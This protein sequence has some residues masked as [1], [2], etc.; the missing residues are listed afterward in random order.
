MSSFPETSRVTQ[1][2][3]GDA[4]LHPSVQAYPEQ[5]ENGVDLSLLRYMLQLPPLERLRLMERKAREM[6]IL[7]EHGRR[8]R[9]AQSARNR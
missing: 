9:E 3:T 1:S 5:D 2:S 7:H 4:P 8:H 6:L